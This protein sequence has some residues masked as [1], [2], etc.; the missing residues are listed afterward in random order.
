[1]NDTATRITG[2]K[3]DLS[4]IIVMIALAIVAESDPEKVAKL[5]AALS[6]LEA[7]ESL[8]DEC[9]EVLS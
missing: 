2:H 7:A 4:D 8:L 6:K 1:M 3:A 5:N 9:L